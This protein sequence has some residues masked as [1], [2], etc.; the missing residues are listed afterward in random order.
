MGDVLEADVVVVAAGPWA[1]GL[2]PDVA[3]GG[4]VTPSRQVLAFAEPPERWRAAWAASPMVIDVGSAGFYAVP[5][6]DGTRL[7]IGDHTFSRAGDPDGDRSATDAEAR[8]V[9]ACAR[10][11]FTDWDDYRLTDTKA[12]FYAV[13]PAERF[14]VE[15]RGRGWVLAGFSGHGFKF[16]PW[17]GDA[18]AA[19]IV[20]E[21][22]AAEVTRVAGGG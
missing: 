18:V 16:G 10:T 9:W 13:E 1:P 19:A 22:D 20:G 2:V 8:A 4:R 7:K 17:V 3:G 5:P 6:V 14:V 21:R 12:C 11:R 15:R